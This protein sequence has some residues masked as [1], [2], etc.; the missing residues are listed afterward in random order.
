[1]SDKWNGLAILHYAAS[2]VGALEVGFVPSKK[3]LNTKGIIDSV[4]S[5]RIKLLWLLGEDEVVL[6][7]KHDAFIVYQG[8]HGDK[9]AESADLILP[10]SAY[11][12]KDGTYVN[13]EGRVQRT[14]TA[15]S[16][17]GDAREDWKI[18]RAFSGFVDKT[19]PYDNI[20]ELR[21]RLAKIN[22]LLVIENSLIKGDIADI[23]DLSI[24]LT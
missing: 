12:E 23:G 4:A 16:P 6:S 3:G 18:I 7:D 14:N 5:N 13:T 17:P 15:V 11:T 10:G 22:E 1:M 8:H 19:L 24:K 2:R 21:D 9:G 20:S